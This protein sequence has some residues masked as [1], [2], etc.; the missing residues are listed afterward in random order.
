MNA[1]F[2]RTITRLVRRR[3]ERGFS[4]LELIISMGIVLVV[5]GGM[6][7][8]YGVSTRANSIDK[9]NVQLLNSARAK[10]EQIQS[11]PYG[12]VGIHVAVGSSSSGGGYFVIDPYY[13]PEYGGA[14]KGD[15][16]LSDALTLR[17]GTVVTRTVTVMAID[18]P[19][20][21]IG[22]NESDG[23]LDPN[24]NTILDYKVL[25]VTASAAAN[26][27]PR[28][29]QTL[30]TVLQGS[31][32]VEIEGATGK[33]AVDNTPPTKLAKVPK[34]TPPAPPPPP[35]SVVDPVTG[36]DVPCDIV[37]PPKS[38]TP[39]KKGTSSQSPC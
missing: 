22:A 18:D 20:D 19:A 10:I 5:A 21:G 37:I 23:V 13:E 35:A 3:L 6:A 30:T 29:T 4:L 27:L 36:A 34:A 9:L 1:R 14:I 8:F 11:V 24:T 16:L 17:D 25:T 7:A 32:A 38:K 12:Q 28:L 26:N 2:R 31:L 33:D 39:G 15:L